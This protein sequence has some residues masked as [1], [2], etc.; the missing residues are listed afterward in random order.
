MIALDEFGGR[1]ALIGEEILRYYECNPN[2][3]LEDQAT[4]AL[5]VLGAARASDSLR[6]KPP[7]T[8]RLDEGGG[9]KPP[10]APVAG[11]RGSAPASSFTRTE[12]LSG[13]ASSR[14]IDELTEEMRA[15]GRWT[16]DPILVVEH[17]GQKYVIDGHH[18]FEA[19]RRAKVEVQYKI[20]SPEEMARFTYK[21][22]DDV[23]RAASEAGPNRL[24][25]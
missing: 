18:R 6:A 19:A 17:N 20:A 4:M 12:S 5:N 8:G 2:P 21:T 22:L 15:A 1:A 24:R 16:K 14:K 3:S 11:F 9:A 7:L 10:E 23:I 25:R 13:G